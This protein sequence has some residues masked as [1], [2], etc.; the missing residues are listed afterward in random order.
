MLPFF[1]VIFGQF[2]RSPGSLLPN[3]FLRW[4]T[5]LVTSLPKILAACAQGCVLFFSLEPSLIFFALSRF[6]VDGDAGHYGNPPP[7]SFGHSRDTFPYQ[8]PPKGFL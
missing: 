3:P 5:C 1:F 8:F 4:H 6:L 7:S 2:D